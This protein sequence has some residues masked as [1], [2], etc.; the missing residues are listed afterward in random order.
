VL[1]FLSLKEPS[2]SALEEFAEQERKKAAQKG[3][4]A[5]TIMMS[6]VSS[7]KLPEHVPKVNSKWDGLP[8][9]ARK[10]KDKD[11]LKDGRTSTIS[12][13]SYGSSSYTR[14]P[15][16]EKSKTIVKS[17]FLDPPSPVLGFNNET[18]LSTPS[19]PLFTL[20]SKFPEQ[21][22]HDSLTSS[23]PST[24]PP[25]PHTADTSWLS[26]AEDNDSDHAKPC[27][28]FLDMATPHDDTQ[29][30][31]TFPDF[32]PRRAEEPEAHSQTYSKTRTGSTS[33]SSSGVLRT[34]PDHAGLK[35]LQGQVHRKD[36]KRSRREAGDWSGGEAVKAMR[37]ADV[38][39]WEMFEPPGKE[40]SVS[41]AGSIVSGIGRK[42]FAGGDGVAQ[43]PATSGESLG[44]G[45]L[46][47]LG[48]SWGRR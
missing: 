7:Q 2:T 19:P 46:K 47:R 8:P 40:G 18:F 30:H 39:P 1:G 4:K 5:S 33:T 38:L 9:S 31:V 43:R 6:G 15:S 3:G 32:P 37:N 45:K 42:D 13:S 23:P 36:E 20:A 25:R 12:M 41:A 21:P 22:R 26:D 34:Y 28:T 29:R 48:R 24:D 14:A 17:T 11:K 10:S 44:G 35:V 27:A 16:P